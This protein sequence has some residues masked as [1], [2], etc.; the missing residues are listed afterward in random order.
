MRRPHMKEDLV[1]LGASSEGHL[2]ILTSNVAENLK[3]S[4]KPHTGDVGKGCH[5]LQHY[6]A[7]R[8]RRH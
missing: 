3:L 4:A 7:S 8:P 6:T 5:D 2:S 1:V